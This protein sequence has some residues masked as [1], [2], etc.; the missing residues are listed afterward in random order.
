MRKSNLSPTGARSGVPTGV[1]GPRRVEA[2]R[3]VVR[4][5]TRFRVVARLLGAAVLGWGGRTARAAVVPYSGSTTTYTVPA[6]GV[7]Q[8]TATGGGGGDGSTTE[9]ETYGGDGAVVGG[10]FSLTVGEQLDILVGEQGSQS[11]SPRRSG[12]WAWP[13]PQPSSAAAP[14]PA[15]RVETQPAIARPATPSPTP[16]AGKP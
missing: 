16:P 13:P 1:A 10:T 15:T 8:I 14:S 9:S 11:P 4:R 5:P 12:C 7:Y 6:T 3:G 2:V